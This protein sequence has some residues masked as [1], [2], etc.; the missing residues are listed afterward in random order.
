MR[1]MGLVKL[2]FIRDLCDEIERQAMQYGESKPSWLKY[3][4]QTLKSCAHNYGD[5]NKS[6]QTFKRQYAH[7]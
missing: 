6:W 7:R 2:T 3:V 5:F 1:D 4:R